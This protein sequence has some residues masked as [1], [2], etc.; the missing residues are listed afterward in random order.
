MYKYYS[1]RFPKNGWIFPCSYC[2]APTMYQSKHDLYAIESYYLCKKCYKNTNKVE[3]KE[4]LIKNIKSSNNCDKV[5][6]YNTPFISDNGKTNHFNFNSTN[7][8]MLIK[9]KNNKQNLVSKGIQLYRN[10]ITNSKKRFQHKKK[11]K[12]SN[13]ILTEVKKINL[14][15]PQ[16]GFLFPELK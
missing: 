16:N 13:T 7:I 1:D 9:D 6:N 8:N 14:I 3:F 4:N 2:K 15:K 5:I 10:T 11:S 12:K